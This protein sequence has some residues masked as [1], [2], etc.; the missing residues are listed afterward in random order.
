VTRGTVAIRGIGTY[1][2][3]NRC[4]SVETPGPW[5][6]GDRLV[7]AHHE[8]STGHRC[9]RPQPPVP[10]SGNSCAGSGRDGHEYP[11]DSE[12]V[13]EVVTLRRDLGGS[14]IADGIR[15]T[16]ETRG[17]QAD[18]HSHHDENHS[19][20]GTQAAKPSLTVR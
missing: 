18:Q 3:G 8:T 17:D 2:M 15:P 12:C 19:G 16:N 1:R 20:D 6:S 13:P 14:P 5:L 7:A 9:P 10:P 11:Q 4:G